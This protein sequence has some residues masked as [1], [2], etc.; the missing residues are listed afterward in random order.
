MKL[1]KILVASTVDR[2]QVAVYSHNLNGYKAVGGISGQTESGI[3]QMVM[4]ITTNRA[5]KAASIVTELNKELDYNIKFSLPKFNHIV[6]SDEIKDFRKEYNIEKPLLILNDELVFEVEQ[7]HAARR[8]NEPLSYSRLLEKEGDKSI[9]TLFKL[10]SDQDNPCVANIVKYDSSNSL[11][12]KNQLVIALKQNVSIP[13]DRGRENE[14]DSVTVTLSLI[15]LNLIK[16]L[17]GL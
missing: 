8:N 2:M 4:D 14:L 5:L 15:N 11:N 3:F 9:I 1:D 10:M 6:D 17:N 12:Y 13:S 16:I 7:V